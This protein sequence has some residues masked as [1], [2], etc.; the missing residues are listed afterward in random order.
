MGFAD[1]LIRQQLN[2]WRRPEGRAYPE[3]VWTY[4]RRLSAG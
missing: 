3:R 1:D 2:G 4:L